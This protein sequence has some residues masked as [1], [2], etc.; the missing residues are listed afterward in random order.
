MIVH[1]FI[2]P[3]NASLKR[4]IARKEFF[5]DDDKDL[6]LSLLELVSFESSH[7]RVKRGGERKKEK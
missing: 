6:S 7:P 4:K 1:T 3:S 5:L 2:L